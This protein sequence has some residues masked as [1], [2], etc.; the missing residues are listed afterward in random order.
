MILQRVLAEDEEEL[1]PPTRVVARSHVEDDGDEAPDVLHGDGLR[2]QVEDG[3]GLVNQQGGVDV[4]RVL[5]EGRAVVVVPFFIGGRGR[6]CAPLRR[7]PER[8]GRA[9]QRRPI[10]D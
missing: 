3:C 5:G 1:L 6:P 4:S 8:H 7:A 9:L 2:M 10:R